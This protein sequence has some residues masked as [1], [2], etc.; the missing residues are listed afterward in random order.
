MNK[1]SHILDI[2]LRSLKFLVLTRIFPN[3]RSSGSTWRWWHLS[4]RTS[5][6]SAGRNSTWRRSSANGIWTRRISWRCSSTAAGAAPASTYRPSTGTRRTWLSR[7]WIRKVILE[8]SK[9]FCNTLSCFMCCV[10]K[11]TIL[12]EKT[13]FKSYTKKKS[14]KW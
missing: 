5:A 2:L 11:Y 3:C 8:K 14:N 7:L 9:D 12:K 6:S 4:W 10:Y 1:T 13:S